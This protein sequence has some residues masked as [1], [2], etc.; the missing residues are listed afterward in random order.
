MLQAK[1]LNFAPGVKSAT[2]DGYWKLVDTPTHRPVNSRTG[3]LA[4]DTGSKKTTPHS[5]DFLHRH[6]PHQLHEHKAEEQTAK[7]SLSL[8]YLQRH[9]R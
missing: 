1:L 6:Q 5:V 4:D 9:S 8:K 7:V 3:Q 2:A